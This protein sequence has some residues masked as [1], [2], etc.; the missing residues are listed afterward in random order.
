M[1][2]QVTRHWPHE[3][4]CEQRERSVGTASGPCW[5]MCEPAAPSSSAPESR[6]SLA[7]WVLYGWQGQELRDYR[8]GRASVSSTPGCG[9]ALMAPD[10][11]V[12]R[13]PGA[14]VK[15]QAVLTPV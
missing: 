14:G 7:G 10:P 13:D 5:T 15:N 12:L 4:A 3:M 2:N 6:C 9:S 11:P 1:D 8:P